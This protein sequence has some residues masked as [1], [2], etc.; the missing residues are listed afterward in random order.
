MVHAPSHEALKQ[1]VRW[2]LV[3]R[4]VAE[5]VTA[6]PRPAKREINPLSKEQ[7]KASL[8]AA[9]DD[10][11]YAPYVLAVTTGIRNGG[12]L[13]PRK[14]I[15]FEA[16]TLTV[17]RSVFNGKISPPKTSSGRRTIRLSKLAIRALKQRRVNVT[18]YIRMGLQHQSG[19]IYQRA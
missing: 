11:L 5:G 12:L 17:N 16:G 13:G 15:D 6:L 14:D 3:P 4:D 2:S 7:V 19:Y 1:A 10:K 8:D 9:K 18:S